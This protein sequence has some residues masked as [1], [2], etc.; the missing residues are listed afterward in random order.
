M[1][2]MQTRAS[3][4]KKVNPQAQGNSKEDKN[5]DTTRTSDSEDNEKQTS[6]QNQ[7]C[8]EADEC[9]DLKVQCDSC[10]T[11]WRCSDV[12]LDNTPKGTIKSLHWSSRS[13]VGT[14]VSG[15]PKWQS[16]GRS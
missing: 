4:R 15:L 1:A 2:G 6:K 12:G 10:K 9:G 11:W 7:P 13:C 16:S 5:S 8:D 14:P 3:S